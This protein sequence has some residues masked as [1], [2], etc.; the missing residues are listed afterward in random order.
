MDVEKTYSILSWPMH[1][2]DERA[3]KRF[4]G[5]ESFFNWA[6][7]EGMIPEGREIRVLDM[8]A[9]TGIAGAALADVL[10]EWGYRVTLTVLDVRRDDLELVEKW[11]EGGEDVEVLGAV[12]DCREPLTF[13]RKQD[14]VLIWGLT[15]PHFDPFDA[16][17]IMKNVASILNTEGSFFIEEFDRIYSLFYQRRYRDILV[18]RK[19]EEETIVSVDEGYNVKRG[20]VMRSYYKLP[21]FE[22]VL[23]MESRLWDLAGLAGMGSLLFDS[24]RMI[25]SDEHGIGGVADVLLFREPKRS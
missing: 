6:V 15:M 25:T 14:V 8:C 9:G 13:L 17:R 12:K 2:D 3:R 23:E 18:E 20:T 10:R 5:I 1:P 24:V 22:K 4:I 11:I 7:K 21:G 19:T 16:A